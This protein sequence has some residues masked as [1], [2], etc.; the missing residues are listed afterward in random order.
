MS[1]PARSLLRSPSAAV[2][3][4]RAADW[5]AARGAHT[6]VLVV[7]PTLEAASELCRAALA[8]RGAG[9]A[10]F[11]WHRVTIPRLAASLAGPTLA[12]R[13]LAPAG[14][15]VL[16][17]LA[18][19]VVFSL[20]QHDEK[21][22]GRFA[23]VADRPGLPRALYATFHELRLAGKTA[24]DLAAQP[25]SET[26]QLAPLLLA[27]EAELERAGLADRAAVLA[28]AA[29]RLRGGAS[30][31]LIERPLLLY[32]VVAASAR[33]AELLGALV[34]RAPATLATVPT[35]DEL[36]ASRLAAALQVELS[37]SADELPDDAPALARV[38]AHLFSTAPQE[39]TSGDDVLVL[40]APGESRECIEL[41]R[42]LH[43]EAERGVPFDRMAVLLRAP[44]QYRA[45]LA[46]A[47]RRAGVPAHFERGTRKPDP[48]GRALLALLAC[49]G[50]G[51]SAR[52]FAEYLSLGQVPELAGDGAPPPAPPA[53]RRWVPP[54]E[55]MLPAAAT[56]EEELDAVLARADDKTPL[57][58][59][60]DPEAAPAA[61]GT[62]RT[63]RR[64]ERLL[65]DAA[66]I[67]GLDRWRRRLRGLAAELELD[68]QALDDPTDPSADRLR[69]NLV[70]LDTLQAFALPLLEDLSALPERALW[71]EWLERLGALAPRALKSPERVLSVLAELSPM[72]EVG[73][74]D[75]S[76]VRLVL[77][78]RLTELVTRPTER[79][80]GR[81]LV[82][83]ID[84]ARGLS[85]DVVLVPGLA[86]RLFPQKVGEEPVLCDADR[87]PLGL[88]TNDDRVAAERLALHLA[89]GAARSRLVLSY[90]R[91]DLEQ[92]RP[93]VPSFY[94]LEVVRAA[95]G[96]LPGFDA[97]MRRAERAVHGASR[98]GW[99][100]PHR[101]TDAVD[102][103]EHDLAL[104]SDLFTRREE[105]T[106]GTARYLLSAN[107][108]LA[109]ALR[110]RA[111]RWFRGW[112]RTDGLI[113]P[114]PL[115]REALGRHLLSSRSFSAT[116]LQNYAA[117]PYKFFLQ[118]VH[119]L[120]PRETPEPAEEL[121]P[122]DRG[123][124]V[125]EVQFELLGRLRDEELLPLGQD[126]LPRALTV[127]DEVL[128]A[129][130]ARTKEKLAP[131]IDRVWDDAIASVLADLR[132]WLRRTSEEPTWA[133]WRFELSFGLKDRR[134]EDPASRDE[135]VALDCGIQLRGS[136]DLVE[137]ARD[138]ALR[139]TDHKTGK[140]RA[141][142]GA[143]IGG[144][145]ILQPVLYALALEK[146]FPDARV[147]AGRLYYAT[148]AGGF[149]DV[150]IPLDARARAAA[151]EV[152]GAIGEALDKG[153]LPAAPK[154]GAC[155]WCD[156]AV[157]CGPY[158]ELRTG[159]YKPQQPLAR[160]KKLRE[161]P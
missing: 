25:R 134:A 26:R 114:I 41:A 65:V 55:E 145:E 52:R 140:R 76:E 16:E 77:N 110:F 42:V 15:L 22:L 115:A 144:G 111:R 50:E 68:L 120:T 9:A 142:P 149:S 75:L 124:L 28:A 98:I 48:A 24:D 152:A 23:A 1:V 137:R 32:D 61:L 84:V 58:L 95:E 135:A 96:R 92:A 112:K 123:S 37:P 146:L 131:A 51:L 89:V 67:G 129:V 125:H 4:D 86:E 56:L 141:D 6:E 102:E 81:V 116:A 11:G 83:P 158:E 33:E 57:P 113:D 13:A 105:D 154:A 143:V 27:Y 70:A 138:G 31:P 14:R 60:P 117:C 12:E 107:P 82:A 80:A 29:Q 21:T 35:G 99:P 126:R 71:G 108:H 19:R 8:L 59:P 88:D 94:G 127:L 72:A 132:E 17:A 64:W 53:D 121:S 20:A 147:D 93:R 36:S 148:A 46:E 2:R 10:S 104:L 101:P 44:G 7:A 133:P 109:R 18:A 118:A 128:G 78:G 5:L 79:R 49:A 47:L 85:F 153:F 39:A 30:H 157:V 54:D 119:R 90:P 136:I 87:A 122:L 155:K 130:A 69:S 159:R 38:Q 73:P 40:S 43:R 45:H 160:L 100:A 106:V 66:V 151:G 150:E 74:V 97:L 63:P 103:A 34:A 91:V 139:A 161:L 3:L 62:L 156:Y